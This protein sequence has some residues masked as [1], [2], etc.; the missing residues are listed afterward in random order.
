MN[1]PHI[2]EEHTQPSGR[3]KLGS[4]SLKALSRPITTRRRDTNPVVSSVGMASGLE[5]YAV[6]PNPSASWKTLETQRKHLLDLPYSSMLQIA[7]DLSPQINKGLFDF[8]R[9][10]NPGTFMDGTPQAVRSAKAFIRKMDG[11]YGSFKSHMDSVFSGIFLAGGIFPELILNN[12][13]TEPVDI[14]LNNP[15]NAKFRRIRHPLR[16]WVWELGQD[17]GLG[18]FD[19][20][21]ENRLVKYIGFDR[22]LITLTDDRWL[23][24]AFTAAFSYWV[25]SAT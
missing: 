9:F 22:T 23:H 16:G 18:G 20:L 11:Y 3:A 6:L 19:S 2:H 17:D 4:K 7:L 5:E 14:A 1:L 10:S 13:A 21:D 15:L 25:S 12:E 8:L 24:R